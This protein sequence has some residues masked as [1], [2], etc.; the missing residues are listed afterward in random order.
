M[1]MK[2]ALANWWASRQW[3]NEKHKDFLESHKRIKDRRFVKSTVFYPFMGN[4]FCYCSKALI[5][6]C[7]LFFLCRLLSMESH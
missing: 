6:V 5:P 3:D 2:K 1:A 7:V 4:L